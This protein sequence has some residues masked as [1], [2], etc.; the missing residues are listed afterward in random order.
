MPVRPS[1]SA[2]ATIS[3]AAACA[4]AVKVFAQVPAPL[5]IGPTQVG[6][7]VTYRLT[8]SDGGPGSKPDVQML[9]LRWKLAQKVLVTLTSADD[10][11]ATPFVATRAADGTL[12]LDNVSTNDPEDRR[13]AVAVGV[14]NR[15]DRFV[16]AA[17]ADAMT[18]KTTLVVQPPAPRAVPLPGAQSTPTPPPPLNIAAGATRS[19][20][21]T[22][23]TL[24]ASGS[25]DHTVSLS[26][27]DGS[28]RGGGRM[29]GGGMGGGGMG[30]GGGMGG[31]GMGGGRTSDSFGSNSGPKSL[32]M[33]TRVAVD[34]HFGTD[35]ALTSGAIVETN[36]AAA[37]DENQPSAQSSTRSWQIQ[38]TP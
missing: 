4:T 21:A 26:P 10:A 22:G 11:Q 34:A 5:L 38:R 3:I 20:D 18:W 15:L 35:G 28:S 30:R 17:P 24:A 14:L 9:A 32:K 33:T 25:I 29:G 1:R 12:T 8:T 6:A 7:A 19:N 37:A 23:M 36:Q 2:V 16:S 27:S 13:V 31:G